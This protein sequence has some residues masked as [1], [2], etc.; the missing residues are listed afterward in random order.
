MQQWVPEMNNFRKIIHNKLTS[1]P[2]DIEVTV[3]DGRINDELGLYIIDIP[4]SKY[5]C[6]YC[7]MTLISNL[8]VQVLVLSR[9]MLVLRDDL[10]ITIIKR[11]FIA[12]ILGH[13]LKFQHILLPNG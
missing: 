6:L 5:I 12:D 9:I 1:A 3:S 13:G 4:L 8:E 11:L 2:C 7:W 10:A